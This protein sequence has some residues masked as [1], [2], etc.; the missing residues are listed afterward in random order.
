MKKAKEMPKKEHHK[1]EMKKQ[2]HH[3]EEMKKGCKM[4]MKKGK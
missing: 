1:K 2:M 4:P 3:K